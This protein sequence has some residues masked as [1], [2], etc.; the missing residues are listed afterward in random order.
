MNLRKKIANKDLYAEYVKILNGVLQL[1]NRVSEVFAFVLAA[2]HWFPNNINHKEVRKAITQ[3]LNIPESNL[4]KYLRVLKDKKL[5]IKSSNNKWIVNDNIRPMIVENEE[6]KEKIVE[7][8][9]TL[10]VIEENKPEVVEMDNKYSKV[11]DETT[12]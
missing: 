1:S 8:S 10:N 6:S 2:D 4:S 9:I 5:I 7:V 12:G 11:E 3:K